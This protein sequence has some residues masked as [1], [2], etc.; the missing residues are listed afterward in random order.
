MMR[1]NVVS[2]EYLNLQK[3]IIQEQENIKEILEDKLTLSINQ[4]EL[5]FEKIII[6]QLKDTPIPAHL[7]RDAVDR[8]ADVISGEN[9]EI[10]NQVSAM[11]KVLTDEVLNEWIKAT[12][13]FDG[14]Y[15]EKFSTDNN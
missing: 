14:A 1:P 6:A 9:E 11:K 2:E 4:E 5:N 7:Y 15:F 10:S 8:I 12:I 3:K 13:I